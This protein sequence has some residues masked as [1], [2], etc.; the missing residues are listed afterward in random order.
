[1]IQ[2]VPEDGELY[3]WGCTLCRYVM[4]LRCEVRQVRLPTF[5]AKQKKKKKE[6]A[7]A[8]QTVGMNI[9]GGIMC[10]TISSMAASRKS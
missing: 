4:Y 5:G 9:N 6:I 2:V 8:N 3:L 10:D 7:A 1:L